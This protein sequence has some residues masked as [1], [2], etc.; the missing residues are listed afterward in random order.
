MNIFRRNG[1]HPMPFNESA[2]ENGAPKWMRAMYYVIRRAG[3]ESDT[4]KGCSP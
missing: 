4:P 1:F 3:V 2:T